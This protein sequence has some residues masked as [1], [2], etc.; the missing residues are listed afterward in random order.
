MART[1]TQPDANDAVRAHVSDE[2][3]TE[4]R[5]SSSA[6]CD[7]PMGATTEARGYACAWHMLVAL[8]AFAAAISIHRSAI[9][10]R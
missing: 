9:R 7:D 8:A 2:A 5:G 4:H 1:R 10:S 6:R 3:D